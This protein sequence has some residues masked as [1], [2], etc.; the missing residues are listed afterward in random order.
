MIL[1]NVNQNNGISLTWILLKHLDS[2]TESRD[3]LKGDQLDHS[4]DRLSRY[5]SIHENWCNCGPIGLPMLGNNAGDL[6]ADKKIRSDNPHDH[7]AK[8]RYETIEEASLII[9]NYSLYY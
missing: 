2:Q 9:L 8:Y 1:S 3:L 6:S 4:S 7:D 5:C